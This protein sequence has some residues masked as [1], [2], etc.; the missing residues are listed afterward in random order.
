MKTGNPFS[1]GTWTFTWQAGR[2]LRSMS[3]IEGGDTITMEFTYNHAGLRTKKVKKVNGVVAET[4]EYILNGK[5]VV[6]LIHTDNTTGTT[7]IV[8][9]LHF[10]YDAQGRVAMVDFNGTLY[11]YA[12]N[13]Q[14]DIIGMFDNSGNLVVKYE[15]DAW[16]KPVST[17]GTLTTTLGELNPFRYRGY[18]WDAETSLFYLI[19]R[20]YAPMLCRLISVD[21]YIPK[22]ISKQP[23]TYCDNIPTFFYD[24][25]GYAALNATDALQVEEHGDSINIKVYLTIEGNIDKNIVIDGILSYWNTTV[26]SSS[27]NT[28]TVVTEVIEGESENGNSVR[29][30]TYEASGITGTI[31]T[32]P[33]Y[34]WLN[35]WS[36]V[37]LYRN[38]Q[39][40]AVASDDDLK[41]NI[42]HEFGHVLGIGDY[43]TIPGHDDN[44]QSIMNGRNMVV[45]YEDV[46]M[47]IPVIETGLWTEWNNP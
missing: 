19:S 39:N 42:A 16:G 18:V 40:G 46:A 47:L 41:W 32:A 14:G 1:D 21:K 25:E 37:F 23:Y 15:Y 5:N 28:I 13:L 30:S 12:H 45:S 20:Y 22:G 27:N 31:C 24:N 43:Y 8:N 6:E 2:Q 33:S 3:K 9:K 17:T 10:Y 4:T 38:Y 29:I 11:S 34:Q 44:F 26:T 7:P 36:Q 35:G